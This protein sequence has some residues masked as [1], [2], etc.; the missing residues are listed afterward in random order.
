MSGT[1]GGGGGG[2]AV[3][4][5]GIACNFLRFDAQVASPNPAAVPTLT[6]GDVL[7]VT[8]A[9]GGGLAAVQVYKGAVLVGG[10]LAN[11]VPRLRECMIAGTSY[12]AT[13]TAL[14]GGQVRVLVEPI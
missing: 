8:L 13:V 9:A 11:L 7:T 14:N 10:L 12:Q 2:R 1:G 6:V 3:S 4:D 5:E